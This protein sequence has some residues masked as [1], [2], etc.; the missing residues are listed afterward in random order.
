MQQRGIFISFEGGEGCG[1]STQIRMLQE[2][3]HGMGREVVCTREPGGTKV[4][5]Q[6]RHILQYSKESAAMV[7]ETELLLFTASR[8][9]LVREVIVPAVQR[10]A[11][12][13][14]DRFLDS[15]AVYQGV[16]RRLDR[17]E[18]RAING[19]AVGGLLPDLTLLLDLDVAEALSRMSGRG[20]RHDR[21]EQQPV[22]FHE[23]VRAG[24]LELAED[25]P[26]RVRRI[27]ASGSPVE[28]FARVR[29]EVERRFDGIFR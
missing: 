5:E 2:L 21:M 20:G 11:A 25:Q 22:A 10:G 27:D 17:E 7:P 18:V 23:A 13:L 24:Y 4:G 14:S 8:A 3:L 15:T 29:A 1:K 12:V 26:A 19:F 28:V 6:I 9:Q 16:A